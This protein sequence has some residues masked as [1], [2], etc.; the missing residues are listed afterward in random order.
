M[1]EATIKYSTDYYIYQ[2]LNRISKHICFIHPNM[3]TLLC[4]LVTFPILHN[5]L[6]NSSLSTFTMLLIIRLILDNLDG[7]VARNCNK[8]SQLGAFLDTLSD[9]ISF[10]LINSAIIYRIYTS[11][12]HNPILYIILCIFNIG[13][14][15]DFYREIKGD[16]KKNYFHNDLHKYIHDNITI[17]SFLFYF[18]VKKYYL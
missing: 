4:F 18:I 7:S 14:I 13:L 11:K 15:I 5:I 10:I 17:L 16:R 8:Y 1:P 12:N 3:I 6:Y 2:V 9:T